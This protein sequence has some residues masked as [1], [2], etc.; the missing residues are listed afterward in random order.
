M[1]S[2]NLLALIDYF[3]ITLPTGELMVSYRSSTKSKIFLELSLLKEAQL[4]ILSFSSLV[5]ACS[6]GEGTVSGS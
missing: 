1:P 4:L 3:D 2:L 5:A 6:K